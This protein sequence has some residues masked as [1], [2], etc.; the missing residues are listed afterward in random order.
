MFNR[1]ITFFEKN[2]VFYSFPITS[3]KL[4]FVTNLVHHH[5][6]PVADEFYKKL[7]DDYKYITTE[8]MPEWLIRGGYDPTINKPYIVR[9]YESVEMQ[10]YA[11][12]LSNE[13]DVVI[14]G[15]APE[16]YV[17]NRI[18]KGKITFRY[19]ERW[20]KNRKWYMSGPK[21]W[22]HYL[23]CHI[24]HWNK[25]LFMLAASAYTCRDVNAIGAYFGKV[26]KWGYFTRVDEFPLEACK[27]LDASSEES[28]PHIM[29]CA[30][31]LR[32]K[33]P[34]LPVMLAKRLKDKGYNFHID[35]YGS[36][37]ELNATM[38][39]AQNLAVDDKVSFCGNLPNEE[40]LEQMRQHEIFLFTSDRN[41]GWG[42]VLN[43]SMS[44]G[45]AVV[46]SNLIGSVPFL[47]QDGKNGMIFMSE[48]LDSLE[49]K[50][51]YLLNNPSKRIEIAKNAIFSMRNIWSPK[52]AAKNFFELVEAIKTKNRELIPEDGPCSRAERI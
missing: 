31:F 14:I 45:C 17:K 21:A 9:A 25:P 23:K 6:T 26:F 7:G 19:S 13:A 4:V 38:Q 34:E 46:A 47:I 5:Q 28:T 51:L 11:L 35:M 39:L 36:G 33:H 1:C 41:E 50:V 22:I 44:N 2:N 29:W 3:M 15:S 10:E 12:K 27:K 40:I 43:E 42:A 49:K 30:R 20:F 16:F 52:N 48:D 18:K 24:I 37:E 32:L 8:P